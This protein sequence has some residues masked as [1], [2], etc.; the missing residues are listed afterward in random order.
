M[1]YVDSTTGGPEDVKF[2][3]TITL[4]KIPPVLLK[5]DPAN[6]KILWKA[7]SRGDWSIVSGKFLYSESVEHGGVA[8]A[9]ALS[10]ALDQNRAQGTVYFH[11]YRIDPDTGQ[12]LGASIARPTRATWPSAKPHPPALRRRTTSVQVSGVLTAHGLRYAAHSLRFLVLRD[13]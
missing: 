5:V 7:E 1:L 4:D 6:G 11:L 2:A 8:L 10:D 9:Q 12:A 3:D 13:G